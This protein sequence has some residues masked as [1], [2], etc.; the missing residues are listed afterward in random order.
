M[1]RIKILY[2]YIKMEISTCQELLRKEMV[3]MKIIT[4]KDVAE[5]LGVSIPTA[6]E[7]MARSDF[8]AF[9]PSERI[10]RTTDEA[11]EDWIKTQMRVKK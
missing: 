9:R 10:I 5:K 8:P 2:F 6:Y 11:L 1:L 7:I 3:Q 4:A